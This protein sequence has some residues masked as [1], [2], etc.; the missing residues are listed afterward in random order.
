MIM[1]IYKGKQ[2]RYGGTHEKNQINAAFYRAYSSFVTD[3][4]L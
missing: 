4:S 1:Y 2:E 3:I